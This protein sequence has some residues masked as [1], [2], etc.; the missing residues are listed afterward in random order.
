M[1]EQHRILILRGVLDFA[2]GIG[3]RPELANLVVADDLAD[4]ITRLRNES[5]SLLIA[6]PA[7]LDLPHC[8][9]R[10][11]RDEHILAVLGKGV[12]LLD[13]TARVV[14]A[15]PGLESLCRTAPTG[16]LL[17]ESLVPEDRNDLLTN[18]QRAIQTGEPFQCRLESPA[19]VFLELSIVPLDGTPDIAEPTAVL[20]CRDVTHDELRRQK[21]EALHQAGRELAPFDP[22]HLAEMNVQERVELLKHNLRRI[23]HDLL[24]YDVIEIRK[25]DPKTGELH[26]LLE[27]GMNPEAA[28]RVLYA[29]LQDNGVTGYVASTGRS[30]LCPDTTTDPLYIEGVAGARSSMT[31]PL[32][33]NEEVVGTFNVESPRPNAFGPEDLQFAEIFCRDVAQALR[34][35]QLLDAQQNCTVIQSIEAINREVA[36]PADELLALAGS[37]LVQF[38]GNPS[39]DP[40]WIASLQR[41]ITNARLIKK[42]IQKVGDE[43]AT[44]HTPPTVNGLQTELLKGARILVIDNE[45]RIRRSAHSILEKFGCQVETAATAMEGIALADTGEYDAIISD[46]RLPDLGGYETYR[47]LK[48]AQPKSRLIL[49]SGFGYDSGHAIVKARMD[50]LRSVIYKPFRVEQLLTALLSPLPTAA[51]VNDPPAATSESNGK[52][53]PLPEFCLSPE[54]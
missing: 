48:Q 44:L 47:R 5:F 53:P 35:L 26:L 39:T 1:A 27:E 38:K 29:R 51:P 7:Q 54:D 4:A 36:L 24:C 20:L 25:L 22:Q 18:I 30:Y 41:I 31:V 6:H 19:H 21:L 16:R 8:F 33:Y 12:A 32:L 34:T 49:M 11:Q 42:S 23:I 14:W 52:A 45:E 13:A 28:Q 43:I 15:N 46:I 2:A 3:L 10:I 17:T 9:D 37:L 50:G 40:A